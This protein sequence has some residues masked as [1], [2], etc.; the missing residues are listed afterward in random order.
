MTV[1]SSNIPHFINEAPLLNIR[2]ESD[3]ANARKVLNY[4]PGSPE[5]NTLAW[6]RSLSRNAD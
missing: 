3:E 2:C 4:L 1:R 5:S 6:F